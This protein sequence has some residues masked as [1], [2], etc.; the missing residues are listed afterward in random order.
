MAHSLSID[1]I[2]AIILDEHNELLDNPGSIPPKALYKIL[3]FVEQDLSKKQSIDAKIPYYWYM[4]GTKAK[5][6]GTEIQIHERG[7]SNRVGCGIN[8]SDI[9]ADSY[10]L[11]QTREIASK[12]LQ[13]YYNRKLEGLTDDMYREAPYNVQRAYRDLDKQLGITED[14][15]QMTLFMDNN[16]TAI[17]KNMLRIAEAF[18]SDEFPDQHE[19]MLIWYGLMRTELLKDDFDLDELKLLSKKFWRHFTLELALRENNDI[20]KEEIERDRD[21]DDIHHEQ[22]R[23]RKD[24][25]EQEREVAEK[26]ARSSEVAKQAAEAFVIPS[27]EINVEV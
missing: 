14:E 27:L 17:K 18:P 21:I 2:T 4:Y 7:G 11:K 10:T 23:I 26:H 19:V 22:K 5:T 20:T 25:L 24:L 16:A 9:E 12:R 6:A 15:D 8:A 1:E 13:H 3:Y